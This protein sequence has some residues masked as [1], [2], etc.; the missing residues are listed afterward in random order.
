MSGVSEILPLDHG[1]PVDRP[2]EPF[3]SSALNGSIVDRFEDIA[4]RFA[5]RLAVSDSVRSFTYAELAALVERIANATAA[6]VADR[7]GPVAILLASNAFFPAALMG[8]LAAGRGYVPLDPNVPIAR[9]QSIATQAGAAAVV[10]AGDPAGA[11]RALMPSDIP[12]VDIDALGHVGGP[13][14]RP[15]AHDLAYIIY[16]SGT[17]GTPKGVYQ[18]H[19]NVLYH[20]MLQSHMMHLNHEDRFTLARSPAAIGATRDVFFALLNGS[21]LHVLPPLELQ[22]AG[23]LHEIQSRKITIYRSAPTLL[24]RIAEVLGPDQRL[25]S[26]RLVMLVSERVDWGD[27]DIFRRIFS[28]EAFLLVTFGSTECPMARWFVDGSLRATSARFPVGRALP[29]RTVSVVD[30]EGNPVTDGEIGEFVVASRDMALGYWRDPEATARAFAVDPAD[31]EVRI[32]KTGDLGRR[33]PDGLFEFVGR[34]DD[35]IKLRGHRIEPAEIERALAGCDD[36]G[37]AAV[38]VRRNDAGVARSLAAYVELR[39]DGRAL[40]PRDLT[41]MLARQLPGYMVPP[42]IVV[43]DKLPRLPNLKVDRVRLAQLDA[44]RVAQAAGPAS[45]LMVEEVARVFE[46]VIG[47]TGATPDDN[48]ASLGGDSLQAIRVAVE[49]E[50]RFGVVIPPRIFQTSETIG[51]LAQWI[52]SQKTR[53]SPSR[54]A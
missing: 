38:L 6:A 39:P 32:F 4:R 11:M 22:P 33:R 53:D 7:D 16:T 49:L 18:D 50:A 27:Y 35:Q 26:V 42:T 44:A 10:S 13:R 25:D 23:L 29:G 5:T 17:T 20:I 30:E 28:P 8:V 52:M 21:S 36:V 24:R 54:E 12:F 15:A 45:D 41:E 47:V 34:K 48:V 37:D 43:V 1:G 14:R 9:N 2:F 40:R 3:P 31:P 19:R 46:R 51:V